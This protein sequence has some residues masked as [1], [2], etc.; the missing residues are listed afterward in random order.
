MWIL[1][2]L[3]LIV[4]AVAICSIRTWFILRSEKRESQTRPQGDPI[5]VPTP[6]PADKTPV[7]PSMPGGT[8]ADPLKSAAGGW[9]R[10][11]L[12]PPE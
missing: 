7:P 5:T 1:E 12:K 11:T 10:S 6:S 2:A 9:V 8:K 4:C 3:I